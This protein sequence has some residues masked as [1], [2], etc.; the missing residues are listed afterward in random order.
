VELPTH[1]VVTEDRVIYARAVMPARG[2]DP[3]GADQSTSNFHQGIGNV[4]IGAGDPSTS[5]RRARTGSRTSTTVWHHD[6]LCNRSSIAEEAN[7]KKR[8]R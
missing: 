2:G 8:R 4:I 3:D 6:G 1:F 5:S 7:A